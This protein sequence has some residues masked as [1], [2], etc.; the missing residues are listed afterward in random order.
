MYLQNE[1]NVEGEEV[2]GPPKIEENRFHYYRFFSL[3]NIRN[4][5]LLSPKEKTVKD[6]NV[7]QNRC[8]IT[9]IAQFLHK[10]V[11]NGKSESGNLSGEICLGN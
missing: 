6:T 1:E 5:F 7:K 2:T 10:F 4:R 11:T 8:K 3:H 9:F